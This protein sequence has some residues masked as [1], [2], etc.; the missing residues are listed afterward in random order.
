MTGDPLGAAVGGSLAPQSAQG[1]GSE[2]YA[3][4]QERGLGRHVIGDLAARYSTLDLPRVEARDWGWRA[5]RTLHDL[6]TAPEARC[7]F[8]GDLYILPYPSGQ[9]PDS[10]VQVALATILR[11][12]APATGK[13]V[14]LQEQLLAGMHRFYDPSV[15]TL[16]RYLP[17]VG[18]EK[19]FDAVDSWYLYHPMVNLAR[20]TAWGDGRARDLLMRS[21]DYGIRAAR[22]FEYRWPVIY[23]IQNFSII[24][25]QLDPG[26]P[27]ERDAGGLYAYLMTSLHHLTAEELYLRE[28]AAAL[29]AAPAGLSLMYQANLTAW[30]AVA[31]ARLWRL[32][33]DEERLAQAYDWLAN[34]F[35]YCPLETSREGYAVH[36][37]TFLSNTC[38]YNS[39]YMAPF[40]DYECVMA[41]REFLALTGDAVDPSARLIATEY[42]RFATDRAWFYYPDQLPLDVLAPEQE[43]G[44][45]RRDLSFPLE[46]LYP[47]GRPAGQVGQEIYG[48]GLAFMFAAF[49]ADASQMQA[50]AL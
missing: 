23:R 15:G 45:I 10:M 40:E 50:H 4:P 42:C 44:I 3:C 34:L 30:G 2:R 21:V 38:M 37:P 49:E 14:P 33:G 27:G 35:H 43:A 28:A 18:E 16:R 17:N 22:H 29:D 36:Y 19:D 46:D 9:Y 31:C 8:E 6:M 26:R 47:D 7:E 41:L 48:A 24:T 39:D 1:A 32:T 11:E 20:L 12:Y 13:S 25:Q 5:E